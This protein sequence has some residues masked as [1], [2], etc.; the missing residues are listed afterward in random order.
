MD[1]YKLAYEIV[2]DALDRMEGNAMMS[3]AD[4]TR[5]YGSPAQFQAQ[6]DRIFEAFE[7]LNRR[8]QPPAKVQSAIDFILSELD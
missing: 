2:R 7:T 3:D 5:Y 4:K 8:N 6:Y 1:N